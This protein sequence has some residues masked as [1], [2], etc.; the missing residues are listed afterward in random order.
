[1]LPPVEPEEPPE[2]EPV[3]L[4]V[5]A[6]VLLLLEAVQSVTESDPTLLRVPVPAGHGVHTAAVSVSE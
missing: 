1:M 3:L 5:E 4:P 6:P 2:V